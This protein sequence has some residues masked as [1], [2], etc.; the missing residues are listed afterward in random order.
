MI[1]TP[2]GEEYEFKELR[3]GRLRLYADETETF[4]SA[5]IGLQEFEER[6]YYVTINE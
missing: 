5:E 4:E 1:I 2:E 6:Y 3:D